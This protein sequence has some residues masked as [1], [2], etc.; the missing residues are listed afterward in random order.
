MKN[1]L[2]LPLIVLIASCQEI[3]SFEIDESEDVVVIDGFISNKSYQDVIAASGDGRYFEVT[4]RRSK[5]I[6]EFSPIGIDYATVHLEAGSGALI[7][8]EHSDNGIY[9][10]CD[11]TFRAVE[12]E[13]YRVVAHFDEQTF[14]SGWQSLPSGEN[15]ISRPKIDYQ[16]RTEY[17]FATG[18]R[19]ILETEML[20]YKTT[21]PDNESST[22]DFYTWDFHTSWIY[23]AWLAGKNSS[24]RRCYVH[25]AYYIDDLTLA[26]VKSKGPVTEIFAIPVDNA[27]LDHQFTVFVTQKKLS[28]EFYE[29]LDGL[30]EQTVRGTIFDSPPYNLPTN[31]TGGEGV[32]TAGFFTVVNEN[33]YRWF[34]NH[35]DLGFA[36]LWDYSTSCINNAPG[37]RPA[38]CYDCRQHRGSGNVTNARPAWWR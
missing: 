24:V 5:P 1:F 35:T 15:I 26:T 34:T 8:L 11:Q 17:S 14:T 20:L 6:G 38:D 32:R 22:P 7:P 33:H 27:R 3:I 2:Y 30:K 13:A 37:P 10:L 4:V 36:G 31:I 18:K 23:E 29:Y 28:P 21:L 19:E 12:G 16:T 25:S 9:K